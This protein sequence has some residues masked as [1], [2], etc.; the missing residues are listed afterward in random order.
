MR[1]RKTAILAALL[2]LSLIFMA[3][4]VMAAEKVVQFN[5]P[6]CNT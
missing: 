1:M 4:S 2:A 3:T 6:G 5:V